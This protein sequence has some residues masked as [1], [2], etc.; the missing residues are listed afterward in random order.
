MSSDI[1]TNVA[2]GVVLV[3]DHKKVFPCHQGS[4]RFQHVTRKLPLQRRVTN[5]NDKYL[6]RIPTFSY[7]PGNRYTIWDLGLHWD[8]GYISSFYDITTI[9]IHTSCLKIYWNTYLEIDNYQDPSGTLRNLPRHSL[10]ISFF[11][12]MNIFPYP[13]TKF[14]KMKGS[15]QPKSP[16]NWGLSNTLHW[17]YTKGAPQNF[18]M[19]HVLAC[20]Y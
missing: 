8:L 2:V 19:L 18:P 10:E 17:I 20:Q 12:M 6:Q 7:I 16:N 11:C 4:H 15:R 9:H 14:N 5:V 3:K 1:C 13:S